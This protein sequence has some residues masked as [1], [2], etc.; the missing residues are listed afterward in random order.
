MATHVFIVDSHPIVR[1]GLIRLIEGT[2]DL[3]FSG[4]AKGDYE[5]VSKAKSVRP[6]IIITELDFRESSGLD[7]IQDLKIGLPET[8]I[9]VFSTYDENLF[10]GRSL[11]A[12]ATGYIMKDAPTAQ[13]LDAIRHVA[14]N[15]IYVSEVLSKN[16]LRGM[17]T[18][19]SESPVD[20]LSD[21]EFQVFHQ[22]GEGLSNQKIADKLGLSVKTVESHIERIKTK[23]QID[24]GRDLLRRAMEWVLVQQ[25]PGS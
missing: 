11:R 7:L 14:A 9:L 24:S 18:P 5:T 12:G 6:D 2:R 17:M 22:M 20:A 21:R 3:E 23:M 15:E 13:L 25:G 4:Y 10:A 1:E 16:L 19:P 8:P